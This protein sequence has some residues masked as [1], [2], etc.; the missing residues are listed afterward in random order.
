MSP[1]QERAARWIETNTPDRSVFLT[2]AFINSPVD[3]AGRLR[4]TTF[5]PY[6]SNLGY[7]PTPREADIDAAYCDGP[8]AAAEIM[9]RYGATYVL[10]SG[11][12]LDCDDL[13]PTDFDSSERFVPVFEDE[14]VSVW[15][16]DPP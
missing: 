15:R 7:D 10:S 4:I 8:E 11:G 3:L 13:D 9:E 2:D 6:V 1:A 12:A 16:L 5:G 14:G